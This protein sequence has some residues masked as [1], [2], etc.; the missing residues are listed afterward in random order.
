MQEAPVWFLG[1]EDPLEK[2]KVT[3]SSIPAWKSHGLYSPRGCKESD[4]TEWLSLSYTYIIFSSVQSLSCVQ[5]FEIS[6]TAAHQASPSITNSQSLL[7]L[8][9]IESVMPSNCLILCRPLLLCPQSFPA[10]GSFQMSQFFATGG[11]SIGV[12]ASASVLPMNI[13]DWFPL[14]LT[15]LIFLQSKGL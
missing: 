5:L 8:M 9:S 14:A 2:G 4:M 15:G 1:W 6:W 7:K 11:Q 12:S 3:H 13:Q 10:S